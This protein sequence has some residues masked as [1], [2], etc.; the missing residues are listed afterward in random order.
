MRDQKRRIGAAFHESARFSLGPAAAI[1]DGV[2]RFGQSPR[3]HF[4]IPITLGVC[5][6]SQF[7]QTAAGALRHIVKVDGFRTPPQQR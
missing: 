2:T 1:S 3:H 7:V 4:I 6:F 5:S